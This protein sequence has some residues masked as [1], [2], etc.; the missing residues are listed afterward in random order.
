MVNPDGV[1]YMLF[2]SRCSK[3][4]GVTSVKTTGIYRASDF[5]FFFSLQA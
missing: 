3:A 5:V 2:L 4:Q 1:D